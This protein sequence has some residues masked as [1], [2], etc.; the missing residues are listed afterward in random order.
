MCIQFKQ[1]SSMPE[2]RSFG[3]AV[4][5]FLS[6]GN[7]FFIHSRTGPP[8]FVRSFAIDNV[9]PQPIQGE[10][11]MEKDTHSEKK[12]VVISYSRMDI[13]AARKLHD[14][15]M[16]KGISV[17]RDETSI[18]SGRWISSIGEA[19][20]SGDV[21]LLMWSRHAKASPMVQNEWTTAL[22]LNKRLVIWC[23]D[24][25]PLHPSLAAINAVMISDFE[26]AFPI[27][28]N[29]IMDGPPVPP[30]IPVLTRLFILMRKRRIAS[31]GF[32]LVLIMAIFVIIKWPL[33]EMIKIPGG[34]YLGG[35]NRTLQSLPDFW[36]DTLPVTNRDY[37][38]FIDAVGSP[39]PLHWENG[40]YPARLADHPVVNVSLYEAR[41]YAKWAKKRLPTKDEWEKTCRGTRGNVYPWGNEWK[42]QTCNTKESGI[43]MTT[44]VGFFSQ[45]KS[46]YGCYDMV[47]NIWE[48]TDTPDSSTPDFYLIVGGAYNQT[49]SVARCYDTRSLPATMAIENVGFRCVS[50]SA[51]K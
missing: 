26:K 50:D 46:P 45:N 18:G 25:T 12:T 37:K 51:V 30:R 9:R 33:P 35:P 32:F 27:L 42:D 40:L 39:A 3:G 38:I 49:M 36:I 7:C 13:K 20:E 28:L 8:L 48:W 2:H 1:T 31:F 47:G 16:K 4:Y 21:T 15:L 6:M 24:Q 22:S 34:A 29:Q 14:R 44:P 41:A 11:T 43:G 19:I 23:L 5:V 10:M 17:W